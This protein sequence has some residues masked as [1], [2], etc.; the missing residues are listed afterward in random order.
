MSVVQLST[1]QAL[2]SCLELV[3]YVCNALNA[4]TAA[5]TSVIYYLRILIHMIK[6]R[7]YAPHPLEKGGSMQQFQAVHIY[8]YCAY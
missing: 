5:K 6:W 2:V 3:I 7:L 4:E 1:P 8:Y